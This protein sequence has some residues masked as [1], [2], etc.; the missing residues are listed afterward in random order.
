MSLPIGALNR[1]RAAG[2]VAL[3]SEGR[4]TAMAP[5]RGSM[6]RY[7]G[8]VIAVFAALC[9]SS[10]ARRLPILLPH[11]PGLGH[12]DAPPPPAPPPLP[13]GE[14]PQS[15]SDLKV[16]PAIRFSASLPNGLRYAILR[17]ATPPGQASLRLRIGAGSLME[18]DDQQGLA[19]FLEHMAFNGST[20]RCPT[21]R[22]SRSSSATVWPSAPTPTPPPSFEA[23]TYKLDL[24]K[25]DDDTVDTSLM[26]LREAAGNCCSSSRPSTPS[27]A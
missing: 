7:L 11:I 5:K 25:A 1:P 26:L 27:A 9:V 12:A 8:G 22:W 18:T 17:N 24:P 4:T 10:G 19:H 2:M 20:H 21:A 6:T 23:T 15:R 3:P 14:W 13:K 16:D